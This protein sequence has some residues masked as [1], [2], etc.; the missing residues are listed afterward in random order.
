MTQEEIRKRQKEPIKVVVVRTFRGKLNADSKLQD[1]TK[2]GE[3]LTMT[4][5]FA[6]EA[7]SLG[8]VVEKGSDAHKAL[9]DHIDTKKKQKEAPKEKSTNELLKELIQ[10]LHNIAVELAKKK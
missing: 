7:V 6:D 9:A 5:E 2:I 10:E 1:F 4:R 8:K 3:E